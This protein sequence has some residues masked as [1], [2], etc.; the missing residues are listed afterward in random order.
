MMHEKKLT[1][2]A[3][4][5]KAQRL[6]VRDLAQDT[7]SALYSLPF[8]LGVIF[9]LISLLLL[10]C[11]TVDRTDP[12]SM[13]GVNWIENSSSETQMSNSSSVPTSSSEPASSSELVSSS[14]ATSSL[15]TSSSLAGVSSSANSVTFGAYTDTRGGVSKVYKT[16]KIQG[17]TWMAENLNYGLQVMDLPSA[18]S[19]GNDAV[20]EKYCYGDDATNC[21]HDGG[22]YQWAEA[23]AL[24]S[25]CNVT[26][27]G[28]SIHSP[29]QGICPLGWHI[30]SALDWNVLGVNLGAATS[31]GAKMKALTTTFIAWDNTT[32]NDGNSSGFSAF[33][34]GLRFETGGFGS[35]G[36]QG[37]FWEAT[38]SSAQ[39]ASDRNL[40]AKNSLL[41]LTTGD[42]KTS[43][44]SVR[45][46][47]NQL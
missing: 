26:A 20:V 44:Y 39:G 7:I 32:Y 1:Q 37:L 17:Q 35:R 28:D 29:H 22:L 16:I 33:P 15:G 42:L 13:T 3:F 18:T 25:S 2:H 41:T 8:N 11:S 12:R 19:Q 45:C 43:G 40:D 34:A 27:C 36:D 9:A 38:E 31:V 6:V 47:E 30:P 10:S 14:A 24:P 46:I 5:V 4:Q 21:A 23:M